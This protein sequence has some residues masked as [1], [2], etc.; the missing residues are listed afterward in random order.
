MSP[1]YYIYLSTFLGFPIFA[2]VVSRYLDFGRSKKYLTLVFLVFLT[3]NFLLFFDFSLKGEYADYIILSLEYFYFCLIIFF[4]YKS[5]NR[6]T[7]IIR[8]IGSAIVAM[9][10]L[11]GL[12]GILLFIVVSQDFEADKIYNFRSNG[13]DYQTRRYSFGFATLDDIRYTFETYRSY[14]Y[15]PFE[16]LINETDF[17]GL[18][19][20]LD[21]REEGFKVN[22]K[23]SLDRQMIEFLSPDGRKVTRQID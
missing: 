13:R 1:S 7:T 8:N 9:G 19:T 2:L 6:L 12:I 21:F 17:L 14:N 3:H 22:I 5:T 4:L 20:D 15:I 11:Q 23:D 18:Q 16:R 10:F